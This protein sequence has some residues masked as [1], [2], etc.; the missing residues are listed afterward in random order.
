MFRICIVWSLPLPLPLR[1]ALALSRTGLTPV[2]ITTWRRWG[3]CPATRVSARAVVEREAAAIEI[4][5]IFFMVCSCEITRP[6]LQSRP[7][8]YAATA[9]CEIRGV[10]H[11]V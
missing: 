1:L 10:D 11:E 3:R 2:P 9:E 8:K 4:R 6:C 5:M 7:E